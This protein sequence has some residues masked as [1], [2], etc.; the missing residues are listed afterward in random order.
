MSLYLSVQTGYPRLDLA[1]K[2]VL[3]KNSKL[4]EKLK[5]DNNNPTFSMTTLMKQGL[6]MKRSHLQIILNSLHN[7]FNGT[8]YFE[9]SKENV[10]IDRRNFGR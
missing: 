8:S 4:F 1:R 10:A 2:F 7:V 3:L 6:K 9:V 5:S